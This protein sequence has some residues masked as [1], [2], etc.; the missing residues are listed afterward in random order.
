MGKTENNPEDVD[1]IVNPVFFEAKAASNTPS[2]DSNP[3]TVSVR[4][5]MDFKS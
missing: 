4:P 3:L 2:L 5:W 1:G